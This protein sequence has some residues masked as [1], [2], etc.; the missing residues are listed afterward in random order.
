MFAFPELHNGL[1]I[2]NL[3]TDH[4][5]LKPFSRCLQSCTVMKVLSMF[6]EFHTD[7]TSLNLYLISTILGCSKKLNV[8]NTYTLLN[9]T[10]YN[11]TYPQCFQQKYKWCRNGPSCKEEHKHDYQHLKI[12]IWSIRHLQLWTFMWYCLA[13]HTAHVLATL[14]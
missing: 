11:P 10:N 6:Y 12:N 13:V 14:F 5:R 7:S 3:I 9:T 8:L 4:V 2:T 1:F